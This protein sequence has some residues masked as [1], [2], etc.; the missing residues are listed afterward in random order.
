MNLPLGLALFL[1]GLLT[2]EGLLRPNVSRISYGDLS[3][4][5]GL[6]AKRVAHELAKRNM[7]FGFKLLKKL[8]SSSSRQNIFFSPMS[9]SIAFSMLSLGAQDSTLEEI[10]QG[11]NFRDM[12]ERDLHQ[13]FYYLIHKLNQEKR[14]IK[15]EIGNILF[16]DQKLK[17]QRDFLRETK[18]VYE[19]E[20][21]PTNFQELEYT[22]Q[23]INNH[24]S[25]KTQ[26]L[27]NNLIRSIEPGTVMLLANYIFFQAR[28]QHKFDPKET[29]ED[30][31]F[32]DK[33][34]S[35]KV[36]MMFHG[37]MYD[38]GYDDKLSC[39]LLEI[40]YHGNIT[41]TFILP[42]EGKMKNLEEGLQVDIFGRWKRLMSKR[43]VNVFLPRLHISGTY[44]LKTT[45]SQL[46]ISKIFEE[47]GDL[48]RISPYRSLKVSE[49]VHKAE[50]K[51]DEKGTQGAAGSGAQT[52]PME[53]PQKVRIN[54]PFMMMVYEKFTPSMIFLGKITNPAGK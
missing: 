29:K 2:T 18:N 24:I 42:D 30:N 41:A 26:G 38:V 45:L 54:R 16:L 48:T 4:V 34:K 32:V 43:V 13:G 27:I 53:T 5:Q 3:Q 47:H 15:L 46:G 10:K 49:A 1:A 35:V 11:F 23:Q 52:L 44:D 9:I 7:E 12:P 50:L 37:G 21:V 17:L 22:Q 8:A 31:F 25:Q 6:K 19:A 36:P 51:M 39:T 40:P 28:W 14:D 33:G 20:I